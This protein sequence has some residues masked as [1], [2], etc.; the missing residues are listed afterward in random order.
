MFWDRSMLQLDMLGH[1]VWAGTHEEDEQ[2]DVGPFLR[3]LH[4]LDM[5]ECRIK[6]LPAE[7]G[8]LSSLTKLKCNGCSVKALHCI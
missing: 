4:T 3:N 7:F 8:R 2:P 5:S 6:T 1:G